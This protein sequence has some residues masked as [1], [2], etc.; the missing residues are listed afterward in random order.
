M[1]WFHPVLQ[2]IATFIGVYAGY[3]GIERFL[4]QHMGIRTQFLWKRHIIIGRIAMLLWTAGMAGGLV[5][6]RLQW[7]V[8]FVTG[9]HYRNAFGMLPL[10]VFGMTSG[11]Y[12]DKKKARRTLLPL[13][14]GSCNLILLIMAF[15]QIRTG[16]QVLKDFIL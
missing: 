6:A 5:F 12:M 14:H 13:L 1:L 4:S 2:L 3:L 9:D 10:I 7:N 8:N 15:L 11:V 16:W